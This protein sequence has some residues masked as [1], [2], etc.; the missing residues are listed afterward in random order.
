MN[1]LVVVVPLKDGSFEKA[2]SLLA[3]GPPF[4]LEAT[5][6]DRHHV[7][8]T[9]LEVVFVFE[10]SEPSATLR[11]SGEDP[12]LWKVA[13]SWTKV[14]AGRPRKAET[15][16]SWERPQNSEALFFGATPGPGDSEGGDVFAPHET[17][18]T[19]VREAAGTGQRRR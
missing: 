13:S 19:A 7:Y 4:E 15:A 1:R 6:F 12:A 8:L 5:E 18:A 14:M 16:Y 2:R 10:S 17:P 3:Q 11:L 9:E